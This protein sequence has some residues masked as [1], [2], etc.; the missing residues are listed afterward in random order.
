M[1]L[2]IIILNKSELDKLNITFFFYRL[3]CIYIIYI[4]NIYIWYESR[5]TTICRKKGA[6]GI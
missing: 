4:I 1:E 6:W 2:E 3:I 5:S